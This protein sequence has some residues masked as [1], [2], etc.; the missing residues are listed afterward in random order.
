[1]YKLIITK[2]EDKIISSLFHE[3]EMVQVNI[4][5]SKKKSI[6]GNIYV[7]KVMNIVKNIQAA[8]VEIENKQICFLPLGENENPIF[9]NPQKNKKICIGDEILVQVTTE[10]VKSKSPSV[11]T[12]LS[13]TGKYCVLTRGRIKLGISNKIED[14]GERERLKRILENYKSKEYGFIIRTNAEGITE[15]VIEKELGI[16]CE[17]YRRICETAVHKT[18]FSLISEA[19]AGYLCDIR[20]G[21][22]QYVQ[23]IITDNVQVYK[24]VES[25]LGKY[26]SDDL[27]KLVLYEDEQISLKHLYGIESKLEKAL[28]ERVWLKSGAYLIIQ[29][30]EAMVVIDVNT[31]KAISGKRPTEETFFKVNIEAAKEIA[32]QLRLRNYSGIIL[33]DFIDMKKNEYKEELIRNLKEYIKEDPV[34]TVFVD[35][36]KLNLVELTRKKTRKPLYEQWENS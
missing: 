28:Q 36:T 8:F 3:Y 10:A 7:G 13:F 16:L 35:M 9:C 19:P 23:E 1:M 24:E 30:T 33:V 26:Q 15:D 17:Q 12:N 22:D 34:K 4:E 29:P 6:V 27:K 25:F 18:C 11:T 31:G 5:N 21:Y 32:K 20:D 2:H 14:I